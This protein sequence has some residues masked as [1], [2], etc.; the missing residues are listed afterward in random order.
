MGMPEDL[1]A[2]TLATIEAL[3]AERRARRESEARDFR[4]IAHLADLYSD[5]DGVDSS[6]PA[7]PGRERLVAL[8]GAGTPEVAEGCVLELA[9]DLHVRVEEATALIATAL[10]VRHR[11]PVLWQMVQDLDV[12]VHHAQHIAYATR[13]LDRDTAG[14][15]DLELS[16]MI[17][18]MSFRRVKKT[19][20]GVVLRHLPPDQAEQKRQAATEARGV[21]IAQSE[22]G[23]ADVAAVVDAADAVQLD[24]QLDRLVQVL[25][26]AGHPGTPNALRAKAL[27]L[28]ATPALATQLLQADLLDQLPTGEDFEAVCQRAGQSGHVCGQITVAPE[29]LLPRAQVVVHLTD[30][31]LQAGDGIARADELQPLL[32][33]WL[34]DLFGHHRITVR[35]VID[36]NHQAP[37]DAYECPPTMREAVTL[38]SPYEV[39]PWSTRRSQ[40]LDLDHT[41][42]WRTTPA[43]Q[44][45][46]RNQST[47]AEPVEAPPQTWA[48]RQA[49]RAVTESS[50]PADATPVAEP[51]QASPH[52]LAPR[53]ARGTVAE[54]RPHTDLTTTLRDVGRNPI[55]AAE[56]VEAPAQ[57]QAPRRAR[58]PAAN[59]TPVA[60]PVEAPARGVTHPDNLG[61]LSRRAHRAKTH[62]GWYLAQPLPGIFLWQTPLGYRYL[63]TASRTLDLGRPDVAASRRHLETQILETEAA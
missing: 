41:I 3:R 20:A 19:V 9:A 1:P 49:R 24:A 39:F 33:G 44:D 53:Q 56:P 57:S 2:T 17:V 31:T 34:R 23:V 40:G 47:A 46:G 55:T 5:V 60:E 26:R 30:T 12:P 29:K 52:V 42:P 38:R 13:E 58:G 15:V 14:L 51:V 21:W 48:P 62:F 18:G 63:T 35:P 4:L 27:G 36:Q 59:V 16:R 8:G 11:L 32:A 61:P 45:P 37:S 54:S 25:R 28:M 6:E 7:L 10:D 22:G 50:P 43:A